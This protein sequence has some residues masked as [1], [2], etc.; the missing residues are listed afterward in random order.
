[1]VQKPDYAQ[2][3]EQLGVDA[4]VSP[5]LICADRIHSFIRSESISTI[6]TIEEGKAVVQEFEVKAGSKL[7]GLTLAKAGFPRGCVVGAL[8]REDGTILVPRGDDEIQALDNMVVFALQGVVEQV[9]GLFGI[10]KG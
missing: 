7:V 3:Y 4:A 9:M 2:I 1:L 5:R 10:R 8:A 6:A